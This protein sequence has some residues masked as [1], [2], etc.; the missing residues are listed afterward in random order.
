[1]SLFSCIKTGNSWILSLFFFHRTHQL[2]VEDVSAK[3]LE[4]ALDT[5]KKLAVYW[6]KFSK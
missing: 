5:E 4:A 3:Q 2:S 6:C 1:L